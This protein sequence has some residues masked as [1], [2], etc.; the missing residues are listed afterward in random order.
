[1]GGVVRGWLMSKK[2]PGGKV[3]G[4]QSLGGFETRD[5]GPRGGVGGRGRCSG[6]NDGMPGEPSG[7]VAMCPG[8]EEPEGVG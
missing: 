6:W 2:G 1:M 3:P 7:K 8:L 4:G 5:R